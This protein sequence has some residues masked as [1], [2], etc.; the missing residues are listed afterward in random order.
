MSDTRTDPTAP[1]P[2]AAEQDQPHSDDGWVDLFAAAMKV[3]LLRARRKGRGGWD[4]PAQCSVDSLRELLAAHIVKG[5]MT[6][7][8]NFAMMVWARERMPDL[9]ALVDHDNREKR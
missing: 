4:D 1:R 8:G 2:E 6:D 5:D 9:Q 3:K 7:V